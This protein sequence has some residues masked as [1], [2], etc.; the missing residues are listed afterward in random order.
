L[1]NG[2]LAELSPWTSSTQSASEENQPAI[3]S[4]KRMTNRGLLVVEF[5]KDVDPILNL[6]D[7]M[8]HSE[9]IVKYGSHYSYNTSFT[10]LNMTDS[11]SMNI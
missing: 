4:F 1:S 9:I 2:D 3:S 6:T 11:K 5:S 10:I 7:F 8:I